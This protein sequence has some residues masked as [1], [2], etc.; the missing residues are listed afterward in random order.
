[1]PQPFGRDAL[2][3]VGGQQVGRDG[4][5]A[6]QRRTD[7]KQRQSLGQRHHDQPAALA[8][9]EQ[10]G[11]RAVGK[12]VAQRQQEQDTQRQR[13]LVQCRHQPDLRSPDAE[14][15]RDIADDRVDVVCIRGHHRGSDGE[16]VFL[17]CSEASGLRGH[18]LR[19]SEPERRWSSSC[20]R[21]LGPRLPPRARSLPQSAKVWACLTL[22]S[23]AARIHRA[24]A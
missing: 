12:A 17:R 2:R 4:K 13:Q 9:G 10:D 6:E 3:C 14:M 1:M 22:I 24:I 16:P 19:P 18:R 23:Q 5:E 8:D 15:A 21:N 11:Q 7:G 20:F